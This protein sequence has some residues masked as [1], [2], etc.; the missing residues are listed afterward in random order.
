MIM[1]KSEFPYYDSTL[2]NVPR[3]NFEFKFYDVRRCS[4]VLP[5]SLMGLRFFATGIYHFYDELC[6]YP[7][8]FQ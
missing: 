4:V 7:Y 2:C 3:R 1:Q 5:L 6:E 8:G